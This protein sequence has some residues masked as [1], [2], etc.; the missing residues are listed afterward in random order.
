MEI[1]KETPIALSVV[2]SIA[3]GLITFCYMLFSMPSKD[4]VDKQVAEVRSYVDKDSE[5][6]R[7]DLEYIRTKVDDIYKFIN[8]LR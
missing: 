3:G 6:S 8:R 7:K 5:R 4:Y 2:I 1:T